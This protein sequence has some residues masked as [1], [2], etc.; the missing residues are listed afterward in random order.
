M[1]FSYDPKC[2]ELEKEY[3]YK[4]MGI[5]N[6]FKDATITKLCLKKP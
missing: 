2:I 6:K 3:T 1:N 5:K 4:V